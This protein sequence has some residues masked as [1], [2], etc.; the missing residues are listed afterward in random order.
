MKRTAFF[1][2]LTPFGKLLLLICII[3]MFAI[4]FALAGLVAGMLIFNAPLNEISNFISNPNTPKAV[5]FL[6]FYQ[7]INQIGVFILPAL[8]FSFLISN[9]SF[10]YLSL[11]K[12]PR[13]INIFVGGLIIYTILPFNSYLDEL[14][15]NMNLPDFLSGMEG[16]MK[17]K[18]DQARKLTE[19]FL[20]THSITGLSV[21][22]LIV[23]LM[24]A[25]GEEL[26]FR[27]VFLKLFNGI[28]KNVHV[29]IL[30]SAVIFSAIHF[31]FYGFIPR[32]M[33]GIVLGYLFVF[34]GNLWVPVFVHFLNNA[35]SAI[36]YYLH[37]NGH[38]EISMEDFGTSSNTAYII[39]SLLITI[40]LMMIVYQKERAD[41]ITKI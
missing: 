37:H 12:V 27:G 1:G 39:G 13:L 24:P 23:A 33:L 3:L 5:S 34:T 32:L 10:E 41:E 21:N 11:N 19:I 18:E 15:R 26:L 2:S 31:Q 28:F 9:S 29:A 4:I 7:V 30:L 16:W 8:F 25:I 38:I 20:N 17:E 36:I 22:I 35:S 40:W 14:N 6:K